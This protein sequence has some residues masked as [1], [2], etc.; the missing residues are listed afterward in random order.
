MGI[1]DPTA[2]FANGFNNAQ[3]VTDTFRKNMAFKALEQTYGPLVGD[4]KLASDVQAYEQKKLTN[5]LDVEALQLG[6]ESTRATNAFNAENRPLVLESNRTAN[7]AAT[8]AQEQTET[9]DARAERLR[10]AGELHTTL[11]GVLGT[12]ETALDGV[13]D[14]NQRLAIFDAQVTE[15]APLIGAE[16]DALLKS[17]AQQRAAIATQGVA[18]IP[19]IRK[20]L[21]D[22]VFA[23]MSPKDRAD[24][25]LAQAKIVTEGAQAEKATAEAVAATAKAAEATAAKGKEAKAASRAL[26][27]FE[28]KQDTVQ[29]YIA[30]AIQYAQEHP[31][32]TGLAAVTPGVKELPEVR[33]LAAKLK[34]IGA[35]IGFNE[36]ARIKSTGATLGPV[37]NYENELL[38]SVQGATDPGM[39][40]EAFI[41]SM[42][43]LSEALKGSAGRLREAYQEDFGDVD[44]EAIVDEGVTP[45]GDVLTYEEWLASP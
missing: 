43:G 41:I 7:K 13:Q 31:L 17:L 14:P 26:A 39:G 12:V 8:Y 15:L 27:D 44:V 25:E 10:K 40:R 21:D 9:A 34:T 5:P 28:A 32:A 38:Q 1:T 42:Q 18:A 33:A 36:L 35:N 30:D 6:N 23:G 37:S 19:T 45:E 16:P 24:L 22:T 11:G 3:M 2:S 20:Q 4:M 29:A